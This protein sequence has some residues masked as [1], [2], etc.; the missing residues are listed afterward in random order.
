MASEAKVSVMDQQAEAGLKLFK[1]EAEMEI[2]TAGAEAY[3]NEI[4]AKIAAL[5]E[6]VKN[7]GGK[8]NK[9]ERTAKSKEISD[10]KVEKQYI[11]ACKVVKGLEPKNGF[12]CVVNNPEPT[13]QANPEPVAA[14]VEEPKE[15]KEKKEK[16]EKPRKQESTGISKEER[17]ELEKL[18]NDLIARKAELKAQGMSGGQ[19]NKDTQVVEW[20]T[21]MNEL[22]EKA[23]PGSTQAAKKETKKSGKSL[24]PD[25][26]KEMEELK[27]EIEQYKH[28]LKT[29]FGYGNKDMKADP[30]LCDMEAKLASFSKRDR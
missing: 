3:K 14:P 11:D 13:E 29:E 18:K 25:E 1:A 21:R 28:K 8:D 19:Q 23:E 9:K 10:I 17:D 20:V 22:K 4:D 15:E 26:Q 12:F 27:T 5:E 24:S 6:E 7:L 2:D 16:K 30:D